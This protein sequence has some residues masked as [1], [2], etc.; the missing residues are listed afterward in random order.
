MDTSEEDGSSSNMASFRGRRRWF[1]LSLFLS[2]LSVKRKSYKVFFFISHQ[3]LHN[4]KLLH[5]PKKIIP[6]VV[7]GNYLLSLCDL[8]SRKVFICIKWNPRERMRGEWNKAAVNRCIDLL[9]HFSAKNLVVNTS[10]G[11]FC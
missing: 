2:Q 5:L 7:E 11:K 6:C 1:F 8:F 4:K 3:S 10:E 9:D